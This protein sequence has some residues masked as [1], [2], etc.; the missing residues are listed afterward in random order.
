MV[1]Q[2]VFFNGGKN[3]QKGKLK[4]HLEKSLVEVLTAKHR[5]SVGRFH[6][7]HASTENTQ[8][9]SNTTKTRTTN[10]L[11]DGY[12]V[13]GTVRFALTTKMHLQFSERAIS[14]SRYKHASFYSTHLHSTVRR[15]LPRRK[16]L[17]VRTKN[18]YPLQFEMI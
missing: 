18:R 5:V 4:I 7:K 11:D 10:R 1:E 3:E 12:N 15:R 17:A 2:R 6:L 8:Q 14:E 9:H 13:V 16:F